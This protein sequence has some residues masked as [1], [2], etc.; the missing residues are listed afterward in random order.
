MIF[1]IIILYIIH[2]I[3]LFLQNYFRNYFLENINSQNHFRKF[4]CFYKKQNRKIHAATGGDSRRHSGKV[5][6]DFLAVPG[7]VKVC[8]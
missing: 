4:I 2:Y 3:Q 8:D 7:S 1:I 6:A 5:P